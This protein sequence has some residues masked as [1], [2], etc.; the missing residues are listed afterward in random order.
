MEDR[1]IFYCYKLLVIV[2]KIAD[3][4]QSPTLPFMRKMQIGTGVFEADFD[5]SW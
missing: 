4:E 1:F 3:V 2:E 5:F